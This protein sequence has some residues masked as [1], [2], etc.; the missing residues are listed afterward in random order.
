MWLKGASLVFTKYYYAVIKNLAWSKKA[1]SHIPDLS[2]ANRFS[3]NDLVSEP[4]RPLKRGGWLKEKKPQGTS[5]VAGTP[6][7]PQ[8]Y[9]QRAAYKEPVMKHS[10]MGSL[11]LIPCGKGYFSLCLPVFCCWPA[12]GLLALGLRRR[13]GCLP[14]CE[15]DSPLRDCGTDTEMLM[16]ALPS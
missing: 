11:P 8:C 5:L 2:A 13:F 12:H 10:H 6:Q 15:E 4:Q 14:G 1:E 3:E 9:L 16:R 7:L